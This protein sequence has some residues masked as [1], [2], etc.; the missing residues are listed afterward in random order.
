MAER[1]QPAEGQLWIVGA[2]LYRVA[3]MNGTGD[4]VYPI[5]MVE[6][7]RDVKALA[8][9]RE[10]LRNRHHVKQTRNAMLQIFDSA[11]RMNQDADY[12]AKRTD[13][14]LWEGTP[15]EWLASRRAEVARG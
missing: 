7:A 5:L 8:E 1:P 6:A 3:S 12:F 15:E 10:A 11:R 13:V 9:E 2:V 14:Q 4:A